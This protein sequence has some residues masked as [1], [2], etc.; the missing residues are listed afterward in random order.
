MSDTNENTQEQDPASDLANALS[1]GDGEFV[2]TEEKKP[3]ITQG[4]LYLLALIAVGGGG[5]WYMY[6]KQSPSAAAAS[7]ETAQAQQTIDNFLSTG[8]AG[9]K[10]MQ[11]MLHNTETIVQEFLDYP[12]VPQVPLSELQTNPFRFSHVETTNVDEDLAKKKKEEERAAAMKASQALNLQSI[13]VNSGRGSCM[14][15]NK[16]YTEGQ[17]LEQFIIEKI[18]R[19]GVIVKTGVYRFELRMQK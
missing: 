6:K 11:E 2:V 19:E 8:P 14:I 1:S 10:Q 15:N 7:V 18:T 3:V 16:M 17:Q 9:I 5:T 12:S 4:M 13:M